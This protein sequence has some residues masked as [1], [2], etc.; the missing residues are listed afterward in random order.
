[1]GDTVK[2]NMKNL[3]DMMQRRKSSVQKPT[4]YQ[5][6]G[7]ILQK[8]KTLLMMAKEGA[9]PEESVVHRGGMQGMF[10]DSSYEFSDTPDYENQDGVEELKSNVTS[11]KRGSQSRQRDSA[12]RSSVS[13]MLR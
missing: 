13:P 12:Q 1:M 10:S 6:A 3:A 9:P 4:K 7:A 11:Q 5:P 2:E 8:K